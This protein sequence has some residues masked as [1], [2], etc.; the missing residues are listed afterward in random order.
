MKQKTRE[1]CKGVENAC[2]IAKRNPQLIPDQ[3]TGTRFHACT[4]ENV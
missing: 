2:R 4:D 3:R 1:F